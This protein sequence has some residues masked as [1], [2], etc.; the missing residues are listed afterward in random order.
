LL[1]RIPAA[2]MFFHVMVNTQ[3][4]F[5]DYS[6]GSRA[7]TALIVS[8]GILAFAVIVWLYFRLI[9]NPHRTPGA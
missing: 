5:S 1:W 8:A 2:F 6:T 4:S 9:G 3:G 7:M